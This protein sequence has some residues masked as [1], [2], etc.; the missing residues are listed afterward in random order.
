MMKKNLFISFLLFFGILGFLSINAFGQ[1]FLDQ[2]DNI[3]GAKWQDDRV[4][5]NGDLIPPRY[6]FDDFEDRDMWVDVIGTVA[7]YDTTMVEITQAA[8]GMTFNLHTNY[9]GASTVGNT[10]IQI[11][12]FFI[13]T[14]AGIGYGVDLSYG[15]D[16]GDGT[17]EVF[18]SGLFTID[19][20][21]YKTSQDFF[22]NDTTATF[23]GIYDDNGFGDVG[24]G[25]KTINVGF[26]EDSTNRLGDVD[27][28]TTDPG[29][30]T[31]FI[32]SFTLDP[33][34]VKAMGLNDTGFDFLFATAECGNDVITGTVPEPAT[35]MLFGLGLLGLSA[36]GRK[37]D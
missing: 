20:G 12:D 2:G 23:A 19:A 8:N 14:G 21:A 10:D 37:R 6:F 3:L 13:T 22:R 11:A 16:D 15:D 7:D 28:S 29:F 4:D 36:I 26:V 31:A 1:T 30:D 33:D 9:A 24:D 25:W 32:Y 5:S 17:F 35:M 18:S 27:V 34:M